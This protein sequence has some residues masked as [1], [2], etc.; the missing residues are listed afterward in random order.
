MHAV[1][2]IIS[3]IILEQALHVD[4]RNCFNSSG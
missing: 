1:E 4:T 3:A 2:E